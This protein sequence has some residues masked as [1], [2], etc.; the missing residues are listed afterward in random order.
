MFVF[1]GGVAGARDGKIQPAPGFYAT[2][3]TVRL[4]V[5][6]GTHYTLDGSTPTTDSP[7]YQEPLQL[8][9]TTVVRY[10][11]F[12]AN[13][14]ATGPVTG[15]TYLIDEPDTKLLTLSVGIDPWRLFHPVKG[16]YHAGPGADPGH[17]KK[18][19][20][21]WWTR[22]S[23]PAHVDLIETDGS[24]VFSA[25][26]DYRMFGGMSRIHPQ[27]SFSIS[28]RKK[29]GKHRIKH[30][31]FGPDGP[32]S[33]QFLVARNA[34]SDWN[35]SYLRD[36]LL[37]GLLQDESWDLDHQAARPCQVYVNGKYWGIFH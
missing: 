25:T 23:H 35:R 15:A 17:W 37:T 20:A 9:K 19:G 26:T 10:V 1:T 8:G 3:V 33:L 13:G 12:D 6:P 21:N 14:Q 5:P 11:T 28:A 2:A 29:Y 30:R 7:L 34:G 31:L 18:P 22:R 24:C 27:K 4:E 16:W 32:K 36:A